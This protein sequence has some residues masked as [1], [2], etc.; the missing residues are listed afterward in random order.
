MAMTLGDRVFREHRH[1]MV[2]VGS[3]SWL[4]GVSC[5]LFAD[6]DERFREREGLILRRAVSWCVDIVDAQVV[7]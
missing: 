4:R 3:R 5:E 7:A 1:K 6:T 2:Y